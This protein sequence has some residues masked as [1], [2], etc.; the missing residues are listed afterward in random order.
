MNVYVI[1]KNITEFQEDEKEKLLFKKTR[2][3]LMN[4][5]I[6]AISTTMLLTIF[7]IYLNNSLIFLE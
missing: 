6:F 2:K 5:K 1:I 7:I 3:H 4:L